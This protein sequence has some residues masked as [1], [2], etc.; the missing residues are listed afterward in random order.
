MIIKLYVNWKT[1]DIIPASEWESLTSTAVR[2]FE[3]DETAFNE[4][5][6]SNYDASEFFNIDKNWRDK[7]L[8]EWHQICVKNGSDLMAE[9]WNTVEITVAEQ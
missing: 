1:H 5:L 4:W 9:N 6:N 3:T 7:V 2:W 8:E